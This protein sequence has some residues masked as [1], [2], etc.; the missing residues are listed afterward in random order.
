MP[1]VRNG[2][3]EPKYIGLPARIVVSMWQIKHW[4]CF[5]TLCWHAR[6]EQARL[7]RPNG[8]DIDAKACTVDIQH[9]MHASTP[10]SPAS[11]CTRK[12]ARQKSREICPSIEHL[13]LKVCPKVTTSEILDKATVFL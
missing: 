10:L 5:F 4:T 12:R 3:I 8:K 13:D 2:I 6:S 7:G 9:A 1:P 11:W